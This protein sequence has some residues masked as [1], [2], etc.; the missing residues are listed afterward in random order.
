MDLARG[1]LTSCFWPTLEGWTDHF[2]HACKPALVGILVLLRDALTALG[3]VWQFF[4]ARPGDPGFWPGIPAC[5][6]G[7]SPLPPRRTAWLPLL[8]LSESFS[9]P[10]GALQD[11]S[12][13]HSRATCI[14]LSL[15]R[16]LCPAPPI[17]AINLGS[18]AF[19]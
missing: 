2:L 7:F 17:M 12:S 13:S 8:L 14:A 3:E 9:S 16:S 18:F 5:G 6:S 1:V 15:S 11:T 19:S 10:R 4:L